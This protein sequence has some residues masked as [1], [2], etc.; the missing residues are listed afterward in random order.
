MALFKAVFSRGRTNRQ[1]YEFNLEKIKFDE[2]ASKK[3]QSELT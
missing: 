1:A 2:E 3:V